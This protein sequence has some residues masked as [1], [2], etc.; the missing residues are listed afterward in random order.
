MS[1]QPST[2]T[3]ALPGTPDVQ[4]PT[5]FKRGEDGLVVGLT[6]PRDSLGRILWKQM[7]NPVHIVFNKRLDE[8][9]TV[10]YGAPA[11]KLVYAEVIK[12]RPVDDSEVLCLLAGL[13]ELADLR[14]YYSA[15]SRIA[16]V[17]PGQNVTVEATISWQPNCEEPDGKT[18]TGEADATYENTKGFPYLAAVAGNRAFVRAVRRGLRI[19]IY[20]DDEIA[21]KDVPPVEGGKTETTTL[22]TP[23]NA[24]QKEAEGLGLS[25]EKVKEGAVGRHR[26]KIEATSE[27]EKWTKF[28]DVP[29]RDCIS[30]I[31]LLRQK[32]SKAKKT[33]TAEAAATPA[34]G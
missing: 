12:T 16:H 32:G 20:G 31:G 6:Y 34:A 33:G 22:P 1:D 23:Q 4:L 19:P 18:S 3:A 24:L 29:P 30:L 5:A 14:G 7:I 25:F 28:D 9:L 11:E 2:T 17:S 27:P 10:K 13:I 21:T 8:Q 26:A 15:E